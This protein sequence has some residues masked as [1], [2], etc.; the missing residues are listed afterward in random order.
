MDNEQHFQQVKENFTPY[1]NP[2]KFKAV[3]IL[4]QKTQLILNKVLT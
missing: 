4:S 3:E 1:P 2:Q